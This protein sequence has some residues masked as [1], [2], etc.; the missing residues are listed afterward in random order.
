M[1]HGFSPLVTVVIGSSKLPFAAAE[2]EAEVAEDQRSPIWSYAT[3][4]VAAS[5]EEQ[6][7]RI[8]LAVRDALARAGVGAVLGRVRS[9][10]IDVAEGARE[11]SFGPSGADLHATVTINDPAA[12][13]GPLR[14]SIGLGE[15]YVDGLWETDDL[16]ALLQIAARE[17]RMMD[18]IR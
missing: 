17:L 1:L 16:V 3:R 18:G 15:T 2:D 6:P 8:R 12:W 9:G 4:H 13:H 5:R 10:R 14:G 7:G 11:R